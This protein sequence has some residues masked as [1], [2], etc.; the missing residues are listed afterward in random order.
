VIEQALTQ[1][2]RNNERW[3]DAELHRL[4]GELM[5]AQGA[6]AGPVEAAFRRA[7]EVAQ[8]QQAKSLELRAATSLARLLLA[9]SRAA[10]AKELLAPLYSWFTEGLDT[11]DLQA[12][13]SLISR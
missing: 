8:S 5:R 12:A 10:E 7:L 13:R 6:D 3:W 4:R 2:L 11:P 1:S 9:Q